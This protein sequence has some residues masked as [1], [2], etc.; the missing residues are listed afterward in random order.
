[1]TPRQLL[2][3]ALVA[4]D[5]AGGSWVDHVRN[6]CA[7]RTPP[8]S[9]VKK[10][11]CA[12]LAHKGL[13]MGDVN[14]KHI[15]PK[16]PTGDLTVRELCCDTCRSGNICKAVPFAC[17]A[18]PSSNKSSVV[19]NLPDADKLVHIP[20]SGFVPTELGNLANRT[21]LPREID[22]PDDTRP[23]LMLFTD[24][25]DTLSGTVPTQIG[26]LSHHRVHLMTGDSFVRWRG[27][28]V[29]GVCGGKNLIA[30]PTCNKKRYAAVEYTTST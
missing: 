5:Y 21:F 2:L 11:P 25:S 13:C 24:P 18:N 27:W 26:R 17:E 29:Y 8:L 14:F 30:Q 3:C 19:L 1:M 20:L 28:R 7:A 6:K 22:D 12:T 4:T 10:M 15:Y 16:A 9:D 23:A